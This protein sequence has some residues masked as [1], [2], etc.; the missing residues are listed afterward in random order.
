M[1]NTVKRFCKS[2][3]KPTRFPPC[4]PDRHPHRVTNTKRRI[5]SVISPDDGHI[6]A[7]NMC[8]KEINIL[9]KIVHQV[10]FIYGIIQGLYIKY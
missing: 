4:I 5:D 10:G 2:Q 1:V 3:N 7:R 8:R 6:V 9:G